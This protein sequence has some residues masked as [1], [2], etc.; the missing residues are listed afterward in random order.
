MSH[1]YVQRSFPLW[2][3]PEISA[4]FENTVVAISPTIS[5]TFHTSDRRRRLL[6]LYTV[7]NL[8]Y[9]AYR[10]IMILGS[11]YQSLISFIPRE[12]LNAKSLACDPLPPPTAVSQ[13]DDEFFKGTENS[14]PRS[15]Q[16]LLA[17][18][19]MFQRL[20]PDA[21]FRAQLQVSKRFSYIHGIHLYRCALFIH[22]L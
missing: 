10:H 17:D 1:L 15:R 16:D 3:D 5:S 12:I 21:L 18:E 2:K 9:S 4:W 11:G 19:R 6:D 20:V 13:Y 14:P 8:R 22:L 7:L